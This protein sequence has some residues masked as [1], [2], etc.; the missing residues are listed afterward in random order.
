MKPA[1]THQCCVIALP[2]SGLSCVQ[3]DSARHFPRHAHA[4]HGLGLLDQGAQASASGRGAVQAHAGDI[5]TNNPGEVHDGRPLGGPSRRWRI[6][7]LPPQWLE[8]SLQAGLAAPA[9]P[10]PSGDS[11]FT[12]PVIRDQRLADALRRL[13]ARLQGAGQ[14]PQTG[15]KARAS[16]DEVAAT[17]AAAAQPPAAD[18]P[19]HGV[20]RGV[21]SA[22]MMATDEALAD[23]C[24]VLAAG[25][26]VTRALPPEANA[27][28]HEVRDRLADEWLQPPSLA[29]LAAMAGLSR[30][31]LLRRF[32]AA[33]GLPPHAWLLQQ[34]AERAR[35]L[36]RGGAGLAQAAADAGFADQSHM[37]RTFARHFGYT[38]GAWLAALR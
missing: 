22:L 30:Y 10:G 19:A 17:A 4:T 13:L 25:G 35:A 16:A 8:S 29:T 23:V 3:T 31:Q 2:G 18:P 26:H 6:V 32:R 38:P 20:V 14:A 1:P 24:A 37:T 28:V 21:E 27:A 5:I 12:A 36:I 34:R 15:G 33:Y 7:H 9:M 11:A